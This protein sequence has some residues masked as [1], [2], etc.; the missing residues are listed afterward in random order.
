MPQQEVKLVFES[1]AGQTSYAPLAVLGYW[2]QQTHFLT[3]GWSALD[4]PIKT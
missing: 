3:P 4:W 1:L 2:L